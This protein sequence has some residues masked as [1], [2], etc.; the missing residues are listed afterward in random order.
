MSWGEML[1]RSVKGSRRSIVSPISN[2]EV[3]GEIALKLKSSYHKTTWPSINNAAT[4]FVH[5]LHATMAPLRFYLRSKQ[6]PC[7]V[8]YNF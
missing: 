7:S 2:L 1:F 4:L 8:C 6:F 3:V 5:Y